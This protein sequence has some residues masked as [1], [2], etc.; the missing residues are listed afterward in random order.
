[1]RATARRA[2][3]GKT[4]F[5]KR[6]E[7]KRFPTCIALGIGALAVIGAMTV[8]CKGKEIANCVSTKVK[9]IFHKQPHGTMMKQCECDS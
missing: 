5:F 8:K 9:S 6:H 1:M 4:M 3:K 2:E 7:K